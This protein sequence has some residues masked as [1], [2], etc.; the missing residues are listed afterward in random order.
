MEDEGKDKLAHLSF[1]VI[2]GPCCLSQRTP[3]AGCRR[4]GELE[5]GEGRGSLFLKSPSTD[6][7]GKDTNANE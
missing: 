6:D 2:N 3:R 1:V 7:E 4:R 5:G